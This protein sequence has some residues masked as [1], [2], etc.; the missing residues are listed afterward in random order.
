MTL[1]LEETNE[2]LCLP[3]NIERRFDG[4]NHGYF[5]LKRIPRLIAEVPELYG[6]PEMEEMVGTI[7]HSDS[8]FRTLGCA[9][10]LMDFA[11]PRLKKRLVSYVDIAFEILSLN[12]EKENYRRL[13]QRFEEFAT[14]FQLPGNVSILFEICPTLFADHQF[15]GWRV[16]LWNAGLGRTDTEARAAWHLGIEV[17]R[18]FITTENAQ[19][20]YLMRNG[21]KTIS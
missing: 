9:I 13:F 7:N 15:H 12:A 2:Y 18:D 16:T 14:P 5:D 20:G 10:A 21:F 17:V 8:L 6:W 19:W 4:I 3:Y 1:R 11:D